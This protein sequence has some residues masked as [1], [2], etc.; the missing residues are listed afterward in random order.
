LSPKGIS[1]SPRHWNPKDR[2]TPFEALFVT[3]VHACSAIAGL[4]TGLF[5]TRI[6][7]LV[8]RSAPEEFTSRMQAINVLAQ[9]LPLL[10]TNN[11]LGW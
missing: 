11:L 10:A 1:S 8:L 3:A 2:H 5:S 7:P 9:A 6:G 4:G